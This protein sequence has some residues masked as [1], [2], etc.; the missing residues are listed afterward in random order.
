MNRGLNVLS[1]SWNDGDENKPSEN[2]ERINAYNGVIVVN[3]A[4]HMRT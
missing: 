1:A 3:R 2:V 4:V